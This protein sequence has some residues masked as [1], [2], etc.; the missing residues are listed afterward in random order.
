MKLEPLKITCTS[1]DCK[2]DLHCFKSTQKM[3][4][5]NKEGQCRTCG[6]ELI[7][8]ERLHQRSFE[9]IE[10][11]FESLKTEMI[12]HHFWHVEIDQKAINHAKRK[13]KKGLEIAT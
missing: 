9:D 2:N 1:S 12:R 4:K 6:T 8:W 3:R 5:E 7:D 11:T 13:G 10:N